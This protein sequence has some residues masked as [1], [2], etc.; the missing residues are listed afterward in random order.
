MTVKLSHG[1]WTC[2]NCG[3]IDQAKEVWDAE[4]DEARGQREKVPY[5]AEMLCQNCGSDDIRE[6]TEDEECS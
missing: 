5:I 2:L 1:L 6:A 4:W 3:F